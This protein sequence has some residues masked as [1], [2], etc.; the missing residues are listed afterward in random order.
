MLGR[1][2]IAAQSSVNRKRI[3]VFMGLLLSRIAGLEETKNLARGGKCPPPDFKP[4]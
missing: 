3:G 1:L 4:V 2:T